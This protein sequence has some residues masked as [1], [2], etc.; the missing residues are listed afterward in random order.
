MKLFE[1]LGQNN[2]K[3]NAPRFYEEHMNAKWRVKTKL[4]NGYDNE[5]SS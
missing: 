5:F 3:Q 1:K 4:V 2:N